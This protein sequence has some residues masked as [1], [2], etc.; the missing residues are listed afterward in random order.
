M[1]VQ[2]SARA[3]AVH[4]C[5]REPV[6]W[7]A[8]VP[9]RAVLALQFHSVEGEQEA[10]RLLS[11]GRALSASAKRPAAAGA[12]RVSGCRAAAPAGQLAVPGSQVSS[13]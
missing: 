7:A 1:N 2:V 4:A 8:F 10:A 12:A 11:G 13:I 3:T 5:V 6:Q 9:S